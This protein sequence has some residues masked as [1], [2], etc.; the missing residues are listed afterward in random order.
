LGYGS[1]YG[2]YVDVQESPN[3]EYPTGLDT[4]ALRLRNNLGAFGPQRDLS[5]HDNTFI[6]RTGP[7]QRAEAQ[8]VRISYANHDG[9]MD[10]ARITLQGNLIKAIVS[11]PDP[12]FRAKALVLDRIDDGINLQISGNVLESNDVSLAVADTGGDVT[13]V[14]LAFNTLRRSDEGASR[15]YIGILAGYDTH[16]IHHV[17]LIGT[18]VNNGATANVDW[19]GSGFKDLTVD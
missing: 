2:N 8:A 14:D 4:V 11:T 5:I 15:P 3:R 16:E 12:S 17:R 10:D 13:G 19:V 6:A 18:A 9:A 1:I 7:G